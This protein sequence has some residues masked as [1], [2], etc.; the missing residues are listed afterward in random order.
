[1]H[2]TGHKAGNEGGHKVTKPA[3][4]LATRSL[5][6]TLLVGGVAAGGVEGRCVVGTRSAPRLWG[7][8]VA[9]CGGCFEH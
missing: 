4:K 2:K 5:D 7:Q 8:E 6:F 9:R 3:E 1:M